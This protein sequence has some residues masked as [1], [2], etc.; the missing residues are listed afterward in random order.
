M[1]VLAIAAALLLAGAVPAAAHITADSA[2]PV[3]D[4]SVVITFGFDHACAATGTTGLTMRM[5]SGSAALTATSPQGWISRISGDTIDWS[6]PEIPSGEAVSFTVTARLAGTVGQTLLFP[7]EQRCADGE[8]YDWA[9]PDES[10]DQPA[11]RLVATAAVLD[12]ALSRPGLAESGS[13]AGPMAVAVAIAV[14]A[15][16]SGA[17]AWWASRRHRSCRG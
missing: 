1:A 4:G 16:V 14:F 10:A 2:E 5:P 17:A 11:P 15:A 3:G 7:T 8:G 12:P 6:G 9:D 13:G